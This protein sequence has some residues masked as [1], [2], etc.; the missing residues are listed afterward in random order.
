MQDFWNEAG[1][2]Q[3]MF[4]QSDKFIFLVV[5]KY[6][7]QLSKQETPMKQRCRINLTLKSHS[8]QPSESFNKENVPSFA[9]SC[10]INEYVSRRVNKI[11]EDFLKTSKPTPLSNKLS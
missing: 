5:N 9:N 3:N 7:A 11:R 10:Q 1:G 8:R 4:I 2:Q 6:G